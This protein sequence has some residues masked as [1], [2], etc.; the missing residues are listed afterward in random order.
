MK[1]ILPG[2]FALLLAVGFSAFTMKPQADL[3]KSDVV[4][5]WFN[6]SDN[7]YLTSTGNSASPNSCTAAGD[8][9]VKGFQSTQINPV[10]PGGTPTISYARN[11]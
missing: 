1:R 7:S 5:N 2:L 3:K 11:H 6:S 8:N 10:Y 9:C 4:F